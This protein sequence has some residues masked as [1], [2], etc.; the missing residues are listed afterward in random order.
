[1]DSD[2]YLRVT[3]R[4]KDLIIRGG[5]NISAREIEDHLIAHPNIT[6][7]ASSATPTNGSAS[8][9]VRSS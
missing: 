1:M 8:G 3:G 2:G 5:T 7:A 6:A 4:I 9:R